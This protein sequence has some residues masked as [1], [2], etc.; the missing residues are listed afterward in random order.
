MTVGAGNRL[1]QA[2]HVPIR[3]AGAGNL[4]EQATHV[5]IRTGAPIR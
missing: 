2:T 4:L 1:E 3:T 5:P